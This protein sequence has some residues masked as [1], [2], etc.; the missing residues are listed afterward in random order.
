MQTGR[1]LAC[2]WLGVALAFPTPSDELGYRRITMKDKRKAFYRTGGKEHLGYKVHLLVPAAVFKKK[3][4][5]IL[6]PDGKIWHR[7]ENQTVPVL[8]SPKNLYYK[9]LK[10]ALAKSKKKKSKKPIQTISLFGRVIAPTWDV[11]GR[12]HILYYKS[13]TYGG[14][15]KKIEG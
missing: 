15:L 8:V 12:C 14:A 4:K 11:K 10:K 1:L 6:R 2:F 9:R 5:E 7:Y 13:K 3:P